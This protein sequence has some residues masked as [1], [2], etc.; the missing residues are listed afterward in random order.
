MRCSVYRCQEVSFK[1]KEARACMDIEFQ[2]SRFGSFSQERA[3]LDNGKGENVNQSRSCTIF[4]PSPSLSSSFGTKNKSVRNIN[5]SIKVQ[6]NC[7][8][9]V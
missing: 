1:D 9:I 3:R 5:D 8:I 2:N 7:L 4:L 6:I